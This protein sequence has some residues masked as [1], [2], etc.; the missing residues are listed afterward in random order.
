MVKATVEALGEAHPLRREL[1]VPPYPQ[2]PVLP[3]NGLEIKL[4]RLLSPEA[5]N[6]LGRSAKV[7]TL[8]ERR[9]EVLR[10]TTILNL[11]N[12]V[13]QP[14]YKA[15]VE[16]DDNRMGDPI[17]FGISMPVVWAAQEIERWDSLARKA[18]QVLDREDNGLKA[19]NRALRI[20][21]RYGEDIN[22]RGDIS[23]AKVYERVRASAVRMGLIK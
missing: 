13:G 22:K 3:Y 18:E 1:T 15:A 11:I 10:E 4:P 14:V 6:N 12:I 2:S 8:L 9:M 16:R 5:I 21:I 19:V 17:I 7:L 23:C 20:M